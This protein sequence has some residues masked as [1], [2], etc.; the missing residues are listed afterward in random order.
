MTQL[1]D[2]LFRMQLAVDVPMDSHCLFHAV[3]HQLRNHN[4][5]NIPKNV[6][7]M[8]R[9]V[10][11]AIR[12]RRHEFIQ[13]D[14]IMQNPILGTVYGNS[15]DV[16]FEEYINRM[17]NGSEYG[18]D[19]ALLTAFCLLC[20][21]RIKIVYTHLDST[22]TISMDLIKINAE[23]PLLEDGSISHELEVILANLS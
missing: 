13:S 11:N 18:D 8:R 17:T 12:Y 22:H 6:M 10:G 5:P 9:E 21:L 19:F 16:T 23:I 15:K 2:K 3:I 4:F 1:I 20:N 7:A 14:L